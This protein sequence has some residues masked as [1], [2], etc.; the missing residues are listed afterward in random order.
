L[1]KIKKI[2]LSTFKEAETLLLE[3]YQN[4]EYQ[5]I[6]LS[7]QWQLSWLKSLAV[8]PTICLFENEN[9]IIGFA[10]LSDNPLKIVSRFHYTLLNQTGIKEAD[11]VWI[12]FNNIICSEEY[13]EGC[14][15][16]LMETQFTDTSNLKFYISMCK[17]TSPWLNFASKSGC[18]IVV[19][20]VVG[21]KTKLDF[22]SYTDEIIDRFSKNT[23][24]QIRRS[25]KAILKNHGKLLISQ[26]NQKNTM[27][28]F[29]SLGN[30]HI[31]RW[32]ES[33]E[34]SG[35]TNE[36]FLSHHTHFLSHF[37][38]KANV[39]KISAGDLTL[40]YCYTFLD[41]ETVYFYCS[42]INYDIETKPIKPGY[43]IHFELMKYYA[44][45][46]FK[47]YDFMGGDSR[48]KQSLSTNKYFFSNIS[49]YKKSLLGKLLYF[50][51]SR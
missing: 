23:R 44:N 38:G 28:F 31:K 14:V 37:P 20:R 8:L 12:E 29:S 45:K 35:F 2:S 24:S 1:I 47:W 49:I 11:Q 27:A 26:A 43:S 4:I 15:Q 46:G 17:E 36:Q 3:C 18:P 34:G 6:F 21:Y 42:G 30:L 25:N 16:A 9:K 51:N 41:K 50:Y 13:L 22:D 48:Y 19:D 7:M 39:L 32:N 5:T 40:G 10:W 33:P